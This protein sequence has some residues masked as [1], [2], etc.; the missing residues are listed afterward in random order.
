M[1]S[2]TAVG[3]WLTQLGMMSDSLF[4]HASNGCIS[5]APLWKWFRS[6]SLMELVSIWKWN[7]II[8]TLDGNLLKHW[9]NRFFYTQPTFHVQEGAIEE[10]KEPRR[11]HSIWV[12]A[13]DWI[14]HKETDMPQWI[15]PMCVCVWIVYPC[16]CVHM[17]M[18]VWECSVH[19]C[20][21]V[22]VHVCTYVLGKCRVYMY[23]VY[24]Y[25][26]MLKWG[27]EILLGITYSTSQC[28]DILC[29]K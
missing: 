16:V 12:G 14:K 20:I 29:I 24:V 28:G 22:N 21:C 27:C 10:L 2:G 13:V 4:G 8:W 18:H 26:N 23:I 11:S 7:G 1:Y 15:S 19:V 25:V 6:C 5:G 17:C 3:S 9:T